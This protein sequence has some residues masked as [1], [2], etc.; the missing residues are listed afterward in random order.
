M[1]TGVTEETFFEPSGLPS[2]EDVAAAAGRLEGKARL[3]PLLRETPLD[4]LTGARVLV[5]PECLQRTGSFKFRGAFNRLSQLTEEELAAGVVAFSSGNHAQGV[6]AAARL[7]GIRAAIVMP[8]DAPRIKIENT[9]ALGA[10]VVPYDRARES[11]EQIAAALAAER[12][13][14]VVPAFN[15]SHII[16]GQGT[17]GLEIAL[18]AQEARAAPDVVLAPCGGGGLISGSALGLRHYFPQAEIYAAEPEAFDDARRSLE[19][20]E[21][22]TVGP[23]AASICD[24]LQAPSLGPLTFALGQRLL[25]GGLS[26]SDDEVRH[27]MAVAFRMLKLVV[28]PGG[29]VALAALLS[30]KIET[31]GRTVAVVLSGGNVDAETF[32][33]CLARA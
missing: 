33:T 22:A 17:V 28:E 20:G 14:V 32:C 9:K 18:Q 19:T 4:E 21:L 2:Y 11:R 31:S 24:A 27:A 29:A 7:L 16:A 10:E 5:K 26:V 13:A 12:G 30:G 23:G 3:T 8:S 25:S 15:D 6:A 1:K